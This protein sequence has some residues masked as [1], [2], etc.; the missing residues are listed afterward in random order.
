MYSVE[1]KA[2]KFVIKAFE[3]KKRI[4]ENINLSFHSISV[5][6]M[7]KDIGCGE[8]VVVSGLLHDIIEDT[9]YNYDY[10]L[11]MFGKN[12]A[13]NVLALS[14]NQNITNF[15]ECKLEFI[16]RLYNQNKNI[17]LIEVADKLHN[18]L[19]D[20]NLWK[21]KGKDA[22]STLSTTYE[23]NKWYYLEM[24]KLFNDKLDKN[25]SLLVRYNEICDLYFK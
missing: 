21:E 4:K 20:Y 1:E 5:G 14:E 12:I 10:I 23:M 2:I 3:N 22:L 13:D 25:N 9:N 16:N 19:S 18:L 8:D 17:I 11:N 6:F 15:K 24:K 7:L